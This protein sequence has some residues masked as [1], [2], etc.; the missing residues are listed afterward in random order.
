LQV[1]AKLL[2][3]VEYG[4][5]QRVG[6]LDAKRVDVTVIA[7]T[8]RDLRADAASGRFRSDLY[9]RLTVME[10]RL[11]PLRERR[12]DI[13]YL[14]A[15]FL[16]EVTGRLRRPLIGM[17][18]AAER[19][20]VQAP[21][22]GNV[23]ELRN[24]IERACFLSDGKMLSE[25]DVLGAMPPSIDTPMPAML[26]ESTPDASTSTWDPAFLTNA[27]RSQVEHALREA[28]GNKAA[29]ARLLGISRRSMFRWVKRLDLS[30]PTAHT[31]E[32]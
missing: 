21:W 14:S 20:L 32:S 16:R 13:P 24:V 1:Q 19:T 8:N 18:A 15:V 27:H 22:P 7:A 4:D 9:Y 2:R 10:I 5:V 30:Q 26:T 25:R 3:A 31:E 11:I 29:A 12:E 23:R 28:G 6:S 17:T